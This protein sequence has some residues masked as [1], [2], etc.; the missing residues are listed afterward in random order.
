[1]GQTLLEMCM[2]SC[3]KLFEKVSSMVSK[4][5]RVNR[6]VIKKEFTVFLT[7]FAFNPLRLPMVHSP[8]KWTL[9]DERSGGYL[10]SLYNE[11]VNSKGL[12]HQ[13]VG[14]SL[15]SKIGVD[16]INAVNYLNG[17]QFEINED[18]LDFLVK[19]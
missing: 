7:N 1:M 16:Q 3:Y 12:V 11:L 14:S 18:M 9:D 19:E 8:N 5:E 4:T 10:H 17:Q 6:I 15:K 2:I 13:E